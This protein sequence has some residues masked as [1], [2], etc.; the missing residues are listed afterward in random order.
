M[1]QGEGSCWGCGWAGVAA[2]L[3]AGAW[4]GA[5]ARAG[6]GNGLGLGLEPQLG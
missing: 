3:G 6:A 1:W 4:A 2:R 5:G